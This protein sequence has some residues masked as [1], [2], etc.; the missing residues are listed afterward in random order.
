MKTPMV[1]CQGYWDALV[2]PGTTEEQLDAVSC[3]EQVL[4]V[5]AV[6]VGAVRDAVLWLASDSAQYV[7]RTTLSIDA[8]ETLLQVTSRLA[9]TGPALVSWLRYC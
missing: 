3:K 6:P 1:S 9:L 7:T 5:D 4:P 2:G 8:G